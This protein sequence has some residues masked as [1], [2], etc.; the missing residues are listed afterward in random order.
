LGGFT[1]VGLP[2]GS[3]VDPVSA[4][5]WQ[6]TVRSKIHLRRNL[7]GVSTGSEVLI[8]GHRETSRGPLLHEPIDGAAY[9]PAA[10]SW[11]PISEAS[12]IGTPAAA[13]WTGDEYRQMI[14]LGRTGGGAAYDPATD[15]W[16][17]LPLEVST[18]VG[19]ATGLWTGDAV[20]GVGWGQGM[21]GVTAFDPGT[22]F[23]TAGSTL[24]VAV[25]ES[26][27]ASWTGREVLVWDRAA[28]WFYDPAA[29]SWREAPALDKFDG[30]KPKQSIVLAAG[31]DGSAGIYGVAWFKTTEKVRLAKLEGDRWRWLD[32]VDFDGQLADAR[33]VDGEIIVV[34]D[35]VP[36]K[37]F[38]FV[39]EDEQLIPFDSFPSRAVRDNSISPVDFGA[40]G[41]DSPGGPGLMVW[42]NLIETKAI[43]N[44]ITPDELN[45]DRSVEI[46]A[47]PDVIQLGHHPENGLPVF[48]RDGKFG[49]YVQLGEMPKKVTE[50]NKPQT[51]SLFKDMRMEAVTLDK[52][53]E[54]L[55]IP[56]SLGVDP[57]D[58]REI[59]A[60]NGPHGPYLTKEPLEEGK[61]ADTRSFENESELLT[62]T[63]DQAV[64]LYAQPKRR[65]GQSAAGPLK[66]L[67]IDPTT[68]LPVV[69][70]NGQFGEYVTDGEVNASLTAT[71]TVERIDITRAS[72]LLATRRQKMALDPAGTKK[73]GAKKAAKKSTAKKGTA[74]KT[75]RKKA[76]SNSS[77]KS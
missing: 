21:I 19:F 15:S 25:S 72:E 42:G 66:E 74:K 28:G 61:R 73:A 8:C 12:W 29:D 69:V 62:M 41:A 46:M 45:T 43:P 63:L 52:A 30:K 56:R 2:D 53:L 75:A 64:A 47:V 23:A 31:P 32:G 65:R 67:G 3:A 18:P 71:D 1:L 10:D 14:V 57:T 20:V 26:A 77:A 24:E 68:D 76:G 60:R 54:L 58:N 6:P 49:P 40:G 16:K 70:K 7:V 35:D 34:G 11:R 27:V 36:V 48:V 59:I 50:D 5:H 17:S 9:D 37:A 55:T 22:G 44:D 33:L 51:S 38:R 4:P 39:P 13:V